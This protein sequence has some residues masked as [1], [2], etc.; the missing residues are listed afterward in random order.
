MTS[1]IILRLFRKSI[2][3]NMYITLS[4]LTWSPSGVYQ[5]STRSPPGVHQESTRS[6]PGVYQESTRTPSGVHQESTR[7]HQESIRSPTGPVGECKIQDIPSELIGWIVL[8]LNK[9]YSEQGIRLS[10]GLNWQVCAWLIIEIEIVEYA[11]WKKR[12][13]S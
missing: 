4:G 7:S 6:P 12:F 11:L 10:G 3:L 8:G 13:S 2:D 5:E 9:W 1:Y